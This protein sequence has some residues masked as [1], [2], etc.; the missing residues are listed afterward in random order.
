MLLRDFI[1]DE[2]CENLLTCVPRDGNPWEGYQP[3]GFTIFNSEGQPV[4]AISSKGVYACK[5]SSV[6]FTLDAGQAINPATPQ[7]LNSERERE[8][9]R[10]SVG[11]V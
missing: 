1:I 6:G 11:G 10:E 5:E 8:R 9:K 2:E 4:L 3:F 7:D